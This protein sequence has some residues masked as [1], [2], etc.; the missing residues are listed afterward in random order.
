MA[1]QT[2]KDA[3]GNHIECDDE[4]TALGPHPNLIGTSAQDSPRDMRFQ[5][6]RFHTP[7]APAPK[8]P[9]GY[10]SGV[11][12]EDWNKTFWPGNDSV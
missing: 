1:K 10:G 7:Q 2:L 4:V 5:P 8:Q 6:I 12:D 11:D 9:T 3:F